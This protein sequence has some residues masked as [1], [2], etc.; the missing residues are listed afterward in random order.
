MKIDEKVIHSVV[1][2]VSEE[3]VWQEKADLKKYFNCLLN[4]SVF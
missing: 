3:S 4:I 1:N 2:N